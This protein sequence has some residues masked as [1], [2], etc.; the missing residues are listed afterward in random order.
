MGSKRLPDCPS[1][2]LT[3]RRNE[4]F[5]SWAAP[6]SSWRVQKRWVFAS[7]TSWG[8]QPLWS[9]PT[10]W[11]QQGQQWNWRYSE[12]PGFLCVCHPSR[13]Q[14]SFGQWIDMSGTI[15]IFFLH[16]NWFHFVS[17]TCLQPPSDHVWMI[18]GH[19]GDVSWVCVL[20]IADFTEKEGHV[21]FYLPILTYMNF[22]TL[23]AGLKCKQIINKVSNQEVHTCQNR[24]IENHMTFFFGKI[25]YF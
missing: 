3:T 18:T 23:L 19:S 25:S 10:D 14:G 13:Q 22:C 2:P 4:Q 17:H 12:W 16:L 15:C 24:Q 1:A 11:K 8:D 21:I 20:K 9:E 5:L 6:W 7:K